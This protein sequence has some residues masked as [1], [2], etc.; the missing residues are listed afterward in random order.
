VSPG[1][2]RPLPDLHGP[3]G[4]LFR[5][6]AEGGSLA[7]QA[8]GHCGRLRHPP[9]VLCP[10]CASEAVRYVS[11]SGRA[12]LFTWTVT[13]QPMHP[14][15]ADQVPYAVAVV[16]VEEGPRLVCRLRDVPHAALAPGLPLRVELEEVAAGVWLPISRPRV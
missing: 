6:W 9:R 2:R 4:A 10:S 16:E 14:A 5:V 8:C 7:V 12:T 1:A 3:H 15:F 13:H 11:L